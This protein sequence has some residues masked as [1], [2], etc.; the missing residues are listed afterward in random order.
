MRINILYTII[1]SMLILGCGETKQK[2]GYEVENGNDIS[3][4]VGDLESTEII[5]CL[6]YT[7][8]SPRD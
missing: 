2:L 6:L 8:P 3:V 1:A 5:S 7:S 4:S